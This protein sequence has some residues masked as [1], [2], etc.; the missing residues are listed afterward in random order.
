MNMSKRPRHAIS[1]WLTEGVSFTL[2]QFLFFKFPCHCWVSAFI[3]FLFFFLFIFHTSGSVL[4][5][6]LSI[7]CLTVT[8]HFEGR[9]FVVIN[10]MHSSSIFERKVTWIIIIIEG[11]PWKLCTVILSGAY[12][13]CTY[14]HWSKLLVLWSTGLTNG[15]HFIL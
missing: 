11:K 12:Q 14:T 15:L 9:I 2:C 4:C 6:L 1:M 5:N 10:G 7:K 8:F 3:M 13:Y